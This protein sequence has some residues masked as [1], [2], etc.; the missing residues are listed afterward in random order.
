MA[1]RFPEGVTGGFFYPEKG[2]G[3]EGNNSSL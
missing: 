1:Y 2:K 3:V